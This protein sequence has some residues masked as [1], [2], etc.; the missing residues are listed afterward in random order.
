MTAGPQPEPLRLPRP[1]L[2]DELADAHAHAVA[3]GL[4]AGP[5]LGE[6]VVEVGARARV[7]AT[8]VIK[9]TTVIVERP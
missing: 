2:G 7:S 3:L 4:E 8:A 1:A 9:A 5:Q 6:E